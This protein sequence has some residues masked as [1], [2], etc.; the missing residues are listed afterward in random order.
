MHACTGFSLSKTRA[1]PNSRWRLVLIQGLDV[2][3]SNENARIE[4][5]AC[6][7]HGRPYIQRGGGSG[8]PPRGGPR[9]GGDV[10]SCL[11]SPRPLPCGW[12][13]PPLPVDVRVGAPVVLEGRAREGRA[14]AIAGWLC[15]ERVPGG[16]ASPS[17]GWG[18]LV[19]SFRS[20]GVEGF[21]PLFVLCATLRG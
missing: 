15:G 5:Y 18:H 11:P 8:R 17:P 19:A 21:V 6:Q 20:R 7:P 16:A 1:V 4:M 9:G 12:Q 14:R 2:P 3:P 13:P 10:G